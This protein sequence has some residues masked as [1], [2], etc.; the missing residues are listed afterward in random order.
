M[1]N[2]S[3]LQLRAKQETLNKT[4][5]EYEKVVQTNLTYLK[6]QDQQLILNDD[7]LTKQI[8]TREN[9]LKMNFETYLPVSIKPLKTQLGTIFQ[10]KQKIIQI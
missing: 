6:K 1:N 3:L 2:I 8:S 7:T 10:E 5:K 4:F 9:N